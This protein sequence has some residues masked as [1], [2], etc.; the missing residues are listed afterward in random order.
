MKMWIAVNTCGQQ[1]FATPLW[2]QEAL[3]CGLACCGKW[4]GVLAFSESEKEMPNGTAK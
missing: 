4:N 1:A 2:P 3:A